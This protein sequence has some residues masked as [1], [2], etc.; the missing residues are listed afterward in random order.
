MFAKAAAYKFDRQLTWWAP[1][2]LHACLV[3]VF[4]SDVVRESHGA[5][6]TKT[7][8]GSHDNDHRTALPDRWFSCEG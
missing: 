5:M 2:P 4:L 7:S 3:A 8:E 6:L 1:D